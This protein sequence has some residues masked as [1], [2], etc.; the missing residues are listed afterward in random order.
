[1]L[2]IGLELWPSIASEGRYRN[3]TCTL[4]ATTRI[5]ATLQLAWCGL[6]SHRRPTKQ[7]TA[8]GAGFADPC[9]DPREFRPPRAAECWSRSTSQ[10]LSVFQRRNVANKSDGISYGRYFAFAALK[11]DVSSSTFF[12]N[13]SWRY[14]LV[15]SKT[16]VSWMPW[17]RASCITHADQPHPRTPKDPAQPPTRLQEYPIR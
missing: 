16:A 9:S 4:N 1:M 3:A 15:R 11:D 10:G 13:I 12:H 7:L 6:Q 5:R 8:A 14:L 2:P 17:T